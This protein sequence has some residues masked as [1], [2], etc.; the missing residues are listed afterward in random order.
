[1][2]GWKA[3]IG[4]LA[5]CK[6]IN[7]VD[8]VIADIPELLCNSVDVS[9]AVTNPGDSAAVVLSYCLIQAS[10]TRP[11]GWVITVYC[12]VL[13]QHLVCEAECPTRKT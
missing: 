6:I 7:E 8:F 12:V 3:A 1:M 13:C 4:R 10:A 9:A 5:A 2:S 11:A